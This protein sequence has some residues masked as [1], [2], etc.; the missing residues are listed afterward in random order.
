VSKTV[1][2]VLYQT[3]IYLGLLSPTGS[4]D[5]PLGKRR[6]A[7]FQELAFRQFPPYLGLAPGGVCTAGMLPYRRW[8]LTSPF[9]PYLGDS[10]DR[11]CVSVA[12][13]L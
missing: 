8:A 6:A 10:A 5:L 4:S 3:I 1:S 12:L 9:H 13:S 2:R 7:A 11:R